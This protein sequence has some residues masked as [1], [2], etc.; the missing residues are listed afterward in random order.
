MAKYGHSKDK[1]RFRIVK[2]ELDRVNN[3]IK[4][5]TKLLV[6]IGKL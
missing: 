5:H 3:L 1:L 6:A 2:E 4:G